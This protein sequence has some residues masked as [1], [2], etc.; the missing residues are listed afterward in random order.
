M[1]IWQALMLAGF[2]C[3]LCF[4]IQLFWW[5]TKRPSG[6]LIWLPKIWLIL[7]CLVIYLINYYFR[8]EADV[9]IL[10]FSLHVIIATF[11]INTYAGIAERSPTEELCKLMLDKLKE[12]GLPISEAQKIPLDNDELIRHRVEN[13]VQSKF[14]SS[15]NGKIKLTS[16]GNY[17]L[18]ALG[19]YRIFLGVPPIG[20]G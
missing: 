17:L 7:P 15:Q 13:L 9:L 6:Y 11:Y 18:K 16:K 1:L 4:L 12:G 10:G 3:G 5:R 8:I 14:I 2:L 19:L 20:E